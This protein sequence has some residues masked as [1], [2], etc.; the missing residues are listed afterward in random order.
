M[1]LVSGAVVPA[2]A[3]GGFRRNLPDPVPVVVLGRL[4]R[5]RARAGAAPRAALRLI[6]AAYA[7]GIRGMVVHA[8]SSD[9]K[10]LCVGLGLDEPQLDPMTLGSGRGHARGL[11][12]RTRAFRAPAC[13]CS[14]QRVRPSSA[15]AF[16]ATVSLTQLATS[17][18]IWPLAMD[19]PSY[20]LR[21]LSRRLR[22]D[23]APVVL[24]RGGN[25]KLGVKGPR[26]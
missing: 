2:A 14:A 15:T 13:R 9:A 26:Y 6:H 12:S 5:P 10:A 21:T 22:C 23:S 11:V 7:I 4:A 16:L 3:P 25:D 8:L 17:R 19:S 1:P 18:A 24:L 20:T